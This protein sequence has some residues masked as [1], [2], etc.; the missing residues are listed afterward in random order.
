MKLATVELLELD[1]D[2]VLELLLLLWLDELELDELWLDRLDPEELE[3][4]LLDWLDALL[5]LDALDPEEL[6]VELLNR[7]ELELL[8]LRPWLLLDWLLD[9]TDD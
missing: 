9:E 4:L 3:L 5:W 1:S 8:L 6:D 7:R 2:C